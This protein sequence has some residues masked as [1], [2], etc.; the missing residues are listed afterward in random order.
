MN[1]IQG[2]KRVSLVISV[3]LGIG[4]LIGGIAIVG[5]KQIVK[6]IVFL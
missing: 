4:A 6:G 3:L 5:D 2:F 1:W